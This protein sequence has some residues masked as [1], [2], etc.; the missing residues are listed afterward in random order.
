MFLLVYCCVDEVQSEVILVCL[1]GGVFLVCVFVFMGGFVWV[2]Y[3]VGDFRVECG[4]V[5]GDAGGCGGRFCGFGIEGIG[6]LF[7]GGFGWIGVVGLLGF[8]C[9]SVVLLGEREQD[10]A[11]VLSDAV[12]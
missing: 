11:G 1:G 2:C 4:V 8:G 7:G 6:C 12:L 10:S 3:M 9:C 5:L